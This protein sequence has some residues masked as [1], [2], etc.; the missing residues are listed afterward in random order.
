MFQHSHNRGWVGEIQ[1]LGVGAEE[2]QR[3]Q[4]PGVQHNHQAVVERE[5][6]PAVPA[7]PPPDSVVWQP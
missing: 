2:P 3:V 7:V 5:E 1:E 6:V 4:E